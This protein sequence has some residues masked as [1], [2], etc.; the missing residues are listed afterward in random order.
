MCVYLNNTVYIMKVVYVSKK[1]WFF[2]LKLRKGL[3]TT[4]PV[5]TEEVSKLSNGEFAIISGTFQKLNDFAPGKKE[6]YYAS[7]PLTN[8]DLENIKNTRYGN[9]D[10]LFLA[11]IKYIASAK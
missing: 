8:K 6:T 11:A 1:Y 5:I 3:L 4:D 2:V 7:R 10:E 9:G